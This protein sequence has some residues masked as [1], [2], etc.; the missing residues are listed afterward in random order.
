[1]V[2]EIAKVVAENPKN[3]KTKTGKTRKPKKDGPRAPKKEKGDTYRL[4]YG[5]AKQGF[6]IAKIAEAREMALTTIEG[7][8]ARGIQD[9]ELSID[10][11]MESDVRDTIAKA[12]KDNPGANSGEMFA[13]LK[14]K[15][16]YG[17][18]KMV[19]AYLAR[20]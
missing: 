11:F 8:I 17:Q 10:T 3:T 15:F 13:K 7:H 6:T 14:G 5:L 4:T 12:L 2:T 19:Q 16:S 9:K 20:A 18:I 1:M